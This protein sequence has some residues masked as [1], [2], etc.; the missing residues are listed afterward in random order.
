METNTSCKLTVLHLPDLSYR[1]SGAKFWEDIK[2]IDIDLVI[3][4]EARILEETQDEHYGIA[5]ADH[6]IFLVYRKTKLELA[7]PSTIIERDENF[8]F[9]RVDFVRKDTQKKFVFSL[10]EGPALSWSHLFSCHLWDPVYDIHRKKVY[11]SFVDGFKHEFLGMVDLKRHERPHSFARWNEHAKFP[12]IRSSTERRTMY[13]DWYCTVKLED[14]ND[15]Y[16]FSDVNSNFQSRNGG[17]GFQYFT[18]Y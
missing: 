15:G 5:R 14:S 11:E 16:D 13:P 18:V 3:L 6:N 4:T 9:W 12:R 10:L 7:S 8:F 1:D 2:K 17:K